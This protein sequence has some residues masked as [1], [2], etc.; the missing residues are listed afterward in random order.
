M[1]F[2]TIKTNYIAQNTLREYQFCSLSRLCQFSSHGVK[3]SQPP[4]RSRVKFI[5][6]ASFQCHN[7][8]SY[9]FIFC[10]VNSVTVTFKGNKV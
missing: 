4:M 10:W 1:H 3:M 5:L 6:S 7:Q 9:L 2:E 8:C